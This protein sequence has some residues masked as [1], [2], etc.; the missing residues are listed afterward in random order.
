MSEFEGARFAELELAPAAVE[1]ERRDDGSL[2]LRSPRPLEPGPE[3]IGALLRQQA[4]SH[5]ERVFLREQAGALWRELSYQEAYRRSREIGRGLLGR[6]LGPERPLAILSGNSIE[7][8]LMALGAMLVGVPVAPISAAYSLMSRDFSRLR[9]CIELLAPGLIFAEHERFGDALA[10]LPAIPSTASSEEVMEDGAAM[11]KDPVELAAASVSSE[12]LAKL[13]FTSGSTGQPKAVCNTHR[14]MLSN[15]QAIAQLWPFL[16]QR[17]PLIVDWLPWSHTFGGNHNF[18]LV[19]RHGGCLVIDAGKPAPGL[20]AP[21]LEALRAFSPTLYFSVPKGFAMLLPEL[22]RDEELRRRFFAELDLIFYAGAALPQPLWRR[23]EE[24]SV[25]ARGERVHMVSAWGSTETAPMATAVHFA[26]DRAG[27]IGLPA[28][29][30]E[31]KLTPVEDKLELRVRGPNVTAGYYKRPEASEAI[32]DAEGFYRTGDAGRLADPDEPAR[33]IVFDGRLAE[34]FKLSSG[35]WVHVG[36][37]RAA[38]IAAGD[39]LIQDLVVAGHDR[40]EVGVFIVP[41]L[42]VC[43]ALCDAP[44]ASI[45]ELAADARLR[46]ALGRALSRH[47][48][49]QPGSSARVGRALILTEPLSI[50]AGE[51]TDK[52]SINQR[53]VLS[54]RAGLVEVLYGGAES[55]I[56]PL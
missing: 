49:A 15:Q 6:G 26:I 22:E 38:L 29:G 10:A 27:V 41:D 51:L 14:M 16:T 28:P 56:R 19:L 35:T 31:I 47:N 54:R 52:G 42:A 37:L 25:R 20:L 8:A 5:P 13:L 45:E 12:S 44:T 23:L 3:T 48:D 4:E 50:D 24:L 11:A 36:A 7:H 1:L 43:R 2:I 32:F 55:V 18:N 33:G 34:N 30:T 9:A 17:A 53:G 21:T 39:S 46:S 40:D